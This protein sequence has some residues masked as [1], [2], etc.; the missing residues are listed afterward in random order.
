V[1]AA[2]MRLSRDGLTCLLERHSDLVVLRSVAHC[3]DL[4]DCA[5]ND[6][7]QV[8]VVDLAMPDAQQQIRSLRRHAPGLRVVGMAAFDDE[9]LAVTC[10]ETGLDGWVTR[11]ASLADL[12][13][14]IKAAARDE[15]H[16]TPRTAAALARRLAT[17]S[18]E[19]EPEPPSASLTAREDE[20]LCLVEEG[21]TNKEIAARLMIALPTVKNH[22]HHILDKLDARGRVEAVMAR[23]AS[24]ASH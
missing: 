22:V 16:C 1:I 11:D 17:L 6:R 23:R 20:I 7:P 4:H 18:A 3:R 5:G 19:R 12:T 10:A 24:L 8:A 21:L 9:T 13:D 15:L 14:A 2:Q